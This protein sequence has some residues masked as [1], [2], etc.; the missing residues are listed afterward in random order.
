[1]F[2]VVDLFRVFWN[3]GAFL[4]SKPWKSTFELTTGQSKSLTVLDLNEKE[5]IWL[6]ANLLRD[7]T[8]SV[9]LCFTVSASEKLESQDHVYEVCRHLSWKKDK[10][11]EEISKVSCGQGKYIIGVRAEYDGDSP[12][13]IDVKV[14]KTSAV[15]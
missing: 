1:M 14:A 6:R 7:P 5:K 10:S 2:V 3:G 9:K 12:V 4:T 13:L 8:T 15:S 11:L